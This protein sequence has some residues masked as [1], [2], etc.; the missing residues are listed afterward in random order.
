LL[1][2]QS[3]N[4]YGTTEIGGKYGYGVAFELILQ[5][6]GT[7]SEKVLHAFRSDPDGAEPFGGLIFD[8]AGNLYGTTSEG[9]S[10]VCSYGGAGC[11]T[12][13]ELSPTDSGEW[14]ETVLIRLPDSSTNWPSNDLVMDS[15]G[16]LY[17]TAAGYNTA[18][19]GA[20]YEVV[21]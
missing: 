7:Y 19:L 13:Y 15:Q 14:T 11:G 21:R 18:S 1:F 9:G 16:N 17:G 12:I 3:G 6:N 10:N 20:I 2:D 8:A 4:L 5:S